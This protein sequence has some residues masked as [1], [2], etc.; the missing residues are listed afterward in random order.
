MNTKFL[1]QAFVL[2]LGSLIFAGTA[3]W[4]AV[5]EKNHNRGGERLFANT[6]AN[7][8]NLGQITIETDGNIVNFRQE[9]SL[10][11]VLE[12]GN[13]YAGYR[14]INNLFNDLETSRIFRRI[15]KETPEDKQKYGLD[16]QEAVRII[17]RDSIGRI[18]DSVRIGKAAAENLYH[19]A[20]TDGENDIFL[21]TGVFNFPQTIAS[22]LQQPLLSIP[23]TDIR[24]L[25]I[26]EQT[27]VRSN[28]IVPFKIKENGKNTDVERFLTAFGFVAAY[29]VRRSADFDPSQYAEPKLITVSTFDGLVATL[30]IYNRENKEYWTSLKISTTTLPTTAVSDYIKSSAFLYE[31]WYF[32]LDPDIGRIL[33]NAFI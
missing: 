31:D 27:A 1:K 17:T 18:L 22:W 15:G 28:L 21:V 10:W 30:E 26:G 7:I 5:P 20:Q 4:F 13:Y 2:F 32:K 11:R 23:P 6:A 3:L 14:Q 25:K 29:D 12:A 16:K 8:G 19:F 33:F 9:D 24:S